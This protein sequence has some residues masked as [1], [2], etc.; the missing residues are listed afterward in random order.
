AAGA[1]I[2]VTQSDTGLERE[3]LTGTQ[4]RFHVDLLPPGDYA[5]TVQYLRF[6]PYQRNNIHV[7]IGSEPDLSVKLELRKE[8]VVVS[9]DAPVVETQ[10]S[11]VSSV[12]E[13]SAIQ[14]L[15]LNGRRFSDL[16]LLTPGV[17]QDP[18]GLTSSSNGDLAFGGLRG[19]HTSFLVDGSDNNN[20]FF[21]QARGRYRAPYQFSNEV[22]QE[23]VVSTNS[24]GAELGGAAGAVVNVVTRSGENYFHGSGFYYIRDSAF[25]ARPPFVS[26]KPQ[27]RQQQ[28]GLTLGGPIRKDKA[29]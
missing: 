28:F 10:S 12:I 11:S 23:F 4:G 1:T 17:T 5:L 25:N 6:A 2:K 24:Y 27:D 13:Q 8:M 26:F 16:A 19:Y 21:A 9:G 15:P 7:D 3:T 14:E 18:R 22:V 20:A 29:F